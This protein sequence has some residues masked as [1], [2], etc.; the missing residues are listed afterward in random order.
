MRIVSILR[1]SELK[2][3]RG[4]IK[5]VKENEEEWKLQ[6]AEGCARG[7]E[8]ESEREREVVCMVIVMLRW[9]NNAAARGKH[10]CFSMVS[11]HRDLATMVAAAALGQAL[12]TITLMAWLWMRQDKPLASFY[13]KHIQCAAS[14]T[15]QSAR[16]VWQHHPEVTLGLAGPSLPRVR[17]PPLCSRRSSAHISPMPHGQQQAAHAPRGPWAAGAAATCPPCR[18][19]ERT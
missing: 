19:R 1:W 13:N 2:E 9:C 6:E 15:P 8:R 18:S 14:R 3:D 7:N 17:Q 4:T 5:R 10:T 16:A 12:G 11:T